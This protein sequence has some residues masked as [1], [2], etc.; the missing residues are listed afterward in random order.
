MN[1]EGKVEE[2]EPN[3]TNSRQSMLLILLRFVSSE[4]RLGLNT[5]GI[6]CAMVFRHQNNIAARN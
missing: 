1:A 2:L 4:F 3:R 6:K 5:D